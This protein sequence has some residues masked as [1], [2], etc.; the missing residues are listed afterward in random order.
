VKFH[1]LCTCVLIII[2]I[3]NYFGLQVS[4]DTDKVTIKEIQIFR[5]VTPC[6]LVKSYRCFG[7]EY[8]LHLQGQTSKK[9]GLGIIYKIYSPTQLSIKQLLLKDISHHISQ[10]HVTTL[11]QITASYTI[12][13]RNPT[14]HLDTK[15]TPSHR[16]RFLHLQ[17]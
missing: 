10:L 17:F 8:C 14:L 7:E 15:N 11:L 12:V 16:R 9:T 5:D 2:S 13:S 6:R 4:T 3:I 1:N